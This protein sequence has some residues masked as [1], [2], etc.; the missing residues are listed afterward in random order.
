MQVCNQSCVDCGRICRC[1]MLKSGCD[2]VI[3]LLYFPDVWRCSACENRVVFCSRL[4][5]NYDERVVMCC[6]LLFSENLCID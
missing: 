4:S 3:E 6:E 5:G 2:S 1:I